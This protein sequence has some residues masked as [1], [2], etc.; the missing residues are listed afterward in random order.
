M[1][2]RD[3]SENR[4]VPIE[5]SLDSLLIENMNKNSNLKLLIGEYNKLDTDGNNGH[6]VRMLA[7]KIVQAINSIEFF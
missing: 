7:L 4:I 3:F 2:I 6:Y 5:D 1:D